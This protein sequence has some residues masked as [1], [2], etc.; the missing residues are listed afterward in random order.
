M[1]PRGWLAVL[2]FALFLV[3][4]AMPATITR[5]GH[6]EGLG[7]AALFVVNPSTAPVRN[8]GVLKTFWLRWNPD[9][10]MAISEKEI[11]GAL[12]KRNRLA[13]SPETAGAFLRLIP[14]R[15]ESVGVCEELEIIRHSN[16]QV[17]ANV[18]KKGDNW[19]EVIESI[20][21]WLDGTRPKRGDYY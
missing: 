20:L 18:N 9:V 16:G 5:K 17:I 6:E 1:Y 12:S 2:S 8:M 7:G 3:G 13:R 21:N 15:R 19:E 4:C 10:E 14:P 11:N